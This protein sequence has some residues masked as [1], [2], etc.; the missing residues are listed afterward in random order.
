MANFNR[1]R[2]NSFRIQY[3]LDSAYHPAL[4]DLGVKL[5]PPKKGAA[6]LSLNQVAKHLFK[7]G[8]AVAGQQQNDNSPLK[9]QIR[10]L[11][12]LVVVLHEDNLRL[13]KVNE[14]Q[15]TTLSRISKALAAVLLNVVEDD[16][17]K[18]AQ[19]FLE[20]LGFSSS[21]SQDDIAV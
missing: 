18:E 20:G 8:L 1:P 15:L 21:D 2:G 17:R 19:T 6:P 11:E 3:R 13:A 9:E 14:I 12:E 5:F 4:V 10:S 16:S 7:L